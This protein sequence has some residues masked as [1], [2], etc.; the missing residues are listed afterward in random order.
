MI[1]N[2]AKCILNTQTCCRGFVLS[3]E[4]FNNKSCFCLMTFTGTMSLVFIFN[5]A[6]WQ[7][8][9]QERFFLSLVFLPASY[10]GEKLFLEEALTYIFCGNR[11]SLEYRKV[12]SS[13]MSWLV[14]HLQT[15]RRLMKG[16]CTVTFGQ[17]VPK[18]IVDWSTPRNFMVVLELKY[19]HW[20]GIM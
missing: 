19:R 9:H 5:W 1:R 6:K 12:A 13:S 10:I 16:K 18:L 7:K 11:I 17:K 8:L 15:F 2:G 20:T 14:A 3:N 4:A